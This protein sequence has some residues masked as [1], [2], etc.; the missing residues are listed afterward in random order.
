MVANDLYPKIHNI[1][2]F[3]HLMIGAFSNLKQTQRR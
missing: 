1:F 2:N 3:F